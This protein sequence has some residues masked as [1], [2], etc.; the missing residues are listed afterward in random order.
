MNSVTEYCV[1]RFL[2]RGREL[3]K[4][5]LRQFRSET[6]ARNAAKVASYQSTGVVVYALTGHPEFE[7]W[8]EPTLIAQLGEVPALELGRT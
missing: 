7:T 1:Q 4:G 8:G 6:T 2:K 3:R 5:D